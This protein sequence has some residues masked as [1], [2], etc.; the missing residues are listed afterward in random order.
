MN[1]LF[2][3]QCGPLIVH[4]LRALHEIT[5]VEFMQ[6]NKLGDYIKDENKLVARIFK[7]IS[8]NSKKEFEYN[9]KRIIEHEESKLKLLPDQIEG[10]YKNKKNIS[11]FNIYRTNILQLFISRQL[12]IFY[13]IFFHA[14]RFI[15]WIKLGYRKYFKKNKPI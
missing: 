7:P 8:N 6:V 4:K 15:W 9:A 3:T 13:I 12:F 14:R 10:V 2:N 11:I 5:N 1:E